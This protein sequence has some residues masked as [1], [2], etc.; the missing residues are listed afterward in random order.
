VDCGE[1]SGAREA[2]AGIASV[3]GCAVAGLAGLSLQPLLSGP[4]EKVS[5][6]DAGDHAGTDGNAAAGKGK[7]SRS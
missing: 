4:V 7:K 1:R 6:F 2:G 5:G 3:A